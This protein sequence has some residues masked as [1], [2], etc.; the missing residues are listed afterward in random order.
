MDELMISGRRFLSSLRAAREHGYHSDYIGQLIRGGKV[1]GQKVGRAWYVDAES[2]TTYLGKESLPYLKEETQPLPEKKEIEIIPEVAS[3]AIAEEVKIQ[4]VQPVVEE[5]QEIPKQTIRE[6]DPEEHRVQITKVGNTLEPT[7]RISIVKEEKKKR[8]T[9][10][11]D[12]APLLPEI[13]KRQSVSRLPERIVSVRV[14]QSELSEEPPARETTKKNVETQPDF[15]RRGLALTGIG[16]LVL[17]LITALSSLFVSNLS[18]GERE[19]A[20]IEFSFP[21]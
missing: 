12:D 14:G 11:T 16:V 18:V 9:Y 3:L 1:K 6:E 4:N 7:I 15:F 20:S 19:T 8:L 13:R 10:I 2:L 21:H 5:V 17:V